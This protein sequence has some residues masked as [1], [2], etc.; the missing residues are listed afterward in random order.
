MLDLDT[1]EVLGAEFT[2][3]QF[4]KILNRHDFFTQIDRTIRRALRASG[5]R[6]YEEEHIKA[7]LMVGGCSFIPSVQRM[8]QRIFGKERVLLNR[9]LDAV[10]RG[11]AAFVAGVDFYEQHPARLCHLKF[12]LPKRG[13]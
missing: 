10:A 13:L 6:G 11:A 5:E 8:L 4:E 12:Q 2:R 9:P 1:G 7:V 3:D